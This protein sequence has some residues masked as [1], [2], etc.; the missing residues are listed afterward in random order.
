MMT[1]LENGQAREELQLRQLI[2]DQMSAICAK[3]LDRLMENYAADVVV[4]DV[5][6]PFQTYGAET[7]RRMWEE[8]LPC[9]PDSFRTE[10]RDLSLAVGGDLALAHWLLRFTGMDEGHPAMQTWMRI[11]AG[12][13]KTRG[14]WEIIHEHAS[15][16]F[17][18]Q[19]AQAAFSP[20]LQ[21]NR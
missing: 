9:V 1:T 18:P 2:A 7:F 15:V 17:D 13:R 4:F 20:E 14:R 10:T 16:P 11:T 21:S 6:P 8:C 19:T 3:D 12:Y 5:K